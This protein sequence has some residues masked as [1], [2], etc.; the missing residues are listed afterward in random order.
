MEQPEL[1]ELVLRVRWP[2]KLRWVA[3]ACVALSPAVLALF[4]R[5][6]VGALVILSAALLVSACN[7]VLWF[8][9][10]DLAKANEAR[11]ADGSRCYQGTELVRS[12]Y[13]RK[14]SHELR[15]ALGATQTILSVVLDGFAGPV[16]DRVGD[17]LRRASTRNRELVALVTDL[18]TL[19]KAQQIESARVQ[20]VDVAEVARRTVEMFQLQA[21]QKPL[22][23]QVLIP[24]ELPTLLGTP[25]AIADLISNLVSNAV[26]YTPPEGKV[27]VDLGVGQGWLYIRVSDTG[28]GIDDDDL[29]HV[30]DEFYR[31]RRAREFAPEG[32]GLGLSIARAVV[33]AHGG[34]IGVDSIPGQGTTFTVTLPAL[35][36]TSPQSAAPSEDSQ[37]SL[38]AGS[39]PAGLLFDG[40]SEISLAWQG[41]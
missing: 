36:D 29:P 20:E 16:P 12:P 28:I 37:V 14:V 1:R 9:T 41:R 35:S 10:S 11:L 24:S 33:E 32:T 22:D 39:P 23:F 13:L 4:L 40:G 30:F 25:E 6:D 8:H 5:V 3:V 26:K 27:I 21:Q 19:S 31:S 38:A 2:G 15:A 18:L 17:L 7:L 34:Q